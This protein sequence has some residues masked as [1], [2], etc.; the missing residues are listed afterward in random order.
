MDGG[1]SGKNSVHESREWCADLHG[2]TATEGGC[3]AQDGGCQDAAGAWVGRGPGE[4]RRPWA[5]KGTR[6]TSQTFRAGKGEGRGQEEAGTG[7]GMRRN[8]EAN[9]EGCDCGAPASQLT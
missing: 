5:G 6:K 2:V 9:P 1:G 7:S 3:T 4:P 8:L